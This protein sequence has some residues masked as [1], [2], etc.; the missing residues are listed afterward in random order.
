MLRKDLTGAHLHD[1]IYAGR[2]GT[3][4]RRGG[5]RRPWPCIAAGESDPGHRSVH[6]GTQ[7]IDDGVDLSGGGDVRRRDDDVIALLAVDRAAHR[8]DRPDHAPGLRA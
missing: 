4:D 7:A 2:H 8:I 1:T 5:T 3:C 6:R